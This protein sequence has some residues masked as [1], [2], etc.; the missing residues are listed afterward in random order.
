MSFYELY[1]AMFEGTTLAMVA[2]L[3]SAKS[4][5]TAYG[6]YNAAAGSMALP[7]SLIA[8]LLLQGIGS[9]PG[10]G[11]TDPFWFDALQALVAGLS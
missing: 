3:A 10:F 2:D 5:G 1:Y 7:A 11:A 9:W 4:R 8:G 6:I